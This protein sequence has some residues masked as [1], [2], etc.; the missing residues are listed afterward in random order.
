MKKL[1]KQ[2][3]FL[4]GLVI[5]STLLLTA[6]LGYVFVPFGLEEMD[7]EFASVAP[8]VG[9]HWLGTD[10]LGVD[11]AARAFA[12]AGRTLLAAVSAVLMALLIALPL[13]AISGF[14]GGRFD[15]VVT[16]FLNALLSFP[17]LLL[18]ICILAILQEKSLFNLFVAVSLVEIPR[19]A[20]QARAAFMVEKQKDYL[21]SA[22]ALGASQTRQ[23]FVT[24]LPN[25][26]SPILVV[27]TM[28]MGGAV[29]EI[30]GLSF[31]G[32]GD[33][34]GSAEWGLMI[35]EAKDSFYDTPWALW[36]PGVA[37]ALTVLGFNLMG[38]GLQDHLNVKLKK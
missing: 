28:G 34:A 15:R 21:M 32:L 36:V 35:A 29:L 12:G 9:G 25:C 30:A 13:G 33:Q 2:K 37:V 5:V 1:L 38:D 8:G 17:S 26:L 19:I 16:L 10:M 20:R 6:A 22:K 27:I 11:V 3:N 7:E 23:I 14:K 18:A 4:L 31:I 24:L